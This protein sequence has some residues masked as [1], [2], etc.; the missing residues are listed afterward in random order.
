MRAPTIQTI[1]ARTG[2]AGVPASL[3]LNGLRLGSLL[4]GSLLWAGAAFAQVPPET[5][6]ADL[7][8]GHSHDHAHAAV[9]TA[10]DRG[11]ATVRARLDAQGLGY[12]V[13]D[14]GLF[15]MLVSWQQENRSQLAFI[16]GQ[17]NGA[18]S[19]AVREV[20]SPAARVPEGGFSAEQ[21]DML[22]RDSQQNVLGAWEIAGDLL[23]YVIKLHDDA[24]G[25]RLQEAVDVAAQIADD[26]EIRLSGGQDTF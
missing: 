1:R 2:D 22:L 3:A 9:G 26:M 13:D 12:E 17:S 7:T 19:S 14:D 8:Q 4:L 10:A 18:G 5:P 6:A 15:R 24:D 20:F 23:F 21:A 16:S 25:A 11:D